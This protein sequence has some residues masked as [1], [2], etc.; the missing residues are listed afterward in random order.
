[1]AVTTNDT[2]FLWVEKYRPQGVQECI[3]PPRIKDLAQKLVDAGEVNNM[4]FH[5]SGGVGKTTLAKA[6]AHDLGCDVLV[7]NCSNENGIDTIRTKL[8]QF[9]SSVSLNGKPKI[10]ILDEADGLSASTSGNGTSAQSALRN[11]IEAYSKNCRFIFTCNFK[12]KLIA[13]LHSR[14]VPLDF[15]LSKEEKAKVVVQFFKRVC[16]ILDIEQVTYEKQV[17]AK[18]IERHFPDFRRVLGELQ[19]YSMQTGGT[20]DGNILAQVKDVDVDTLFDSLKTKDFKK[21]RQ[22]VAANLDNDTALIIRRIFDSLNDYCVPQS[23]PNMIL[24]LAD[25]SYKAAFVADQEI[26]LTACLTEMMAGGEWK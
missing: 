26:N 24:L 7:L 11:F 19:R 1:M 25:Y 10:A 13:P 3:L 14:L 8:T 20:I 23:V 18:I 12:D 15:T 2:E 4:L 16:E 21:M 6:I 22:W 17:I 5:G 9:A